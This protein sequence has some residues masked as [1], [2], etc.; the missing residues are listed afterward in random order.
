MRNLPLV[1]VCGSGDLICL[2]FFSFFKS[3]MV[4]EGLGWFG[5]YLVLVSELQTIDD[6]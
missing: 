5:A 3:G 2:A 6:S 1:P 4:L